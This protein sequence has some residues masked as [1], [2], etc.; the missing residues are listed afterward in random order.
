MPRQAFTVRGRVQGVG[1]RWFATQTAEDFGIVGWVRNEGDGS[2]V[3]EAGGS[4]ADLERFFARLAEGPPHG[5]VDALDTTDL[6]EAEGVDYW[7]SFQVL[8]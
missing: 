1:Y 8:R 3:G 4:A 7:R 6:P 5:R 2:V